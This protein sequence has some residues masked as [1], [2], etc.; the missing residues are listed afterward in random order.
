MSRMACF[1]V[2]ALLA[3]AAAA[4]PPAL[5]QG[6]SV[7]MPVTTSAAAM[8]DADAADSLVVAV[9]SKGT[10]YLEVTAMT[11]AELSGKVK[12]ALTKHPGQRVYLKGD[13]RTPYSAVAEV[14][15]ALRAAGVKAP[16]LLTSQ[17]DS[18]KA[19]YVPPMGLEVL[20]A[21]PAPDGAQ[22]MTVKA[23]NG[24]A[25]DAELKKSVR[26]DRPVVLAAEGTAP[27]GEVVRAVDVCHAEGAKVFLAMPAK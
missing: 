20:V 7:Q 12:A 3:A 5:R 25:L 18:T 6:V 2:G 11:P 22:T 13:A 9:T 23:G 4:Q 19:A 1:C 16:I 26:R 14:L 24:Q 8:P 15:G 17:R 27:F 21:P 10:V